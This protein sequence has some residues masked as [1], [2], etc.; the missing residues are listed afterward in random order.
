MGERVMQAV[1]EPVI[2]IPIFAW[3]EGF[4]LLMFAVTI[5]WIVVRVY[6]DASIPSVVKNRVLFGLLT[7]GLVVFLMK[8]FGQKLSQDVHAFTIGIVVGAIGTIIG[9][10]YDTDKEHQDTG[11]IS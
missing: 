5:C 1:V 3:V 7:F 4:V 11:D 8:E 2:P 6:R 9:F 10:L